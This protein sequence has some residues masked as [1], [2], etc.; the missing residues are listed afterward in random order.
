MFALQTAPYIA[1]SAE[2]VESCVDLRLG[3][4]DLHFLM[5]EIFRWDFDYMGPADMYTYNE[6]RLRSLLDEIRTARHEALDAA[7]RFNLYNKGEIGIQ[8]GQNAEALISGLHVFTARR[9][10][11]MEELAVELKASLDADKRKVLEL[12]GDMRQPI[13]V[14]CEAIQLKEMPV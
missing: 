1:T 12:L 4:E 2:R 7:M 6:P 14:V 8:V 3:L 11:S 10:Y 13:E 9:E 5:Q